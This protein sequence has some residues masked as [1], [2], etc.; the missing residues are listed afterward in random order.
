MTADAIAVPAPG[1]A[2]TSKQLAQE[3]GYD[4]VLS[5]G[6]LAFAAHAGFL[7]AV[8]DVGIKV[9]G[10]MGTSSGAIT[11]ALYAAGYTPMQASLL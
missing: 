6:F 5:S 8:E 9:R 1:V 2:A 10:V 7:A 4:I 3:H 11:G